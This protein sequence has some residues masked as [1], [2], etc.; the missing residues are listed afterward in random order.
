MRLKK[1]L[2]NN[3]TFLSISDAKMIRPEMVNKRFTHYT[4]C[5]LRDLGGQENWSKKWCQKSSKMVLKSSFRHPGVRF[6]RFL[7]GLIEVRFLMI[8]WAV[9]K[10]EKKNKTKVWKERFSS[11]GR[12]KRWGLRRAFGVCKSIRIRQICKS[13][14]D[15][16]SPASR[17]RRIYGLPPLPPA[18]EIWFVSGVLDREIVVLCLG[19]RRVVCGFMFCVF[20]VCRC[21]WIASDSCR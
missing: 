7:K 9:I 6:W 4:C 3:M 16:L 21:V 17:G 14:W 2:W 19:F 12:R 11:K 13:I 15:A 18:S 20:G 5:K 1:R 8:L 10:N